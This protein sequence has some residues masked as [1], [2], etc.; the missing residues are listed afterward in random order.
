M[1]QKE[2]FL[3]LK[4]QFERYA[5]IKSHQNISGRVTQKPDIANALWQA[6]MHGPAMWAQINRIACW[7]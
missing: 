1:P 4:G 2:Q 3:P 7:A 6:T 5:M